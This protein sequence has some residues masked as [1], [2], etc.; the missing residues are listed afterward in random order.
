MSF[1]FSVSDFVY[2]AQLAYK[3]SVEFKGAPGACRDFTK[4]LLIFHQLLLKTQSLIERRKLDVDESGQTTLA[5]SAYSCKELLYV[6]IL[7]CKNVPTDIESLTFDNLPMFYEQGRFLQGLRRKLG[8]IKFAKKIPEFQSAISA[9]ID[10]LTALNVV[11]M[12][13]SLFHL[14]RHDQD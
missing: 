11:L 8:E 3:L 9:R 10:A 1:G 7:G 4:D 5:A 14:C 6:Q 2:C 12:R 13:Y